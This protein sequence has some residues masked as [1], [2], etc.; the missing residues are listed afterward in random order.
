MS[1]RV[2]TSLWALAWLVFCFAFNRCPADD[3][4]PAD[5]QVD[6]LR[7]S[8]ASRTWMRKL[9][10]LDVR[11]ASAACHHLPMMIWTFNEAKAAA[12]GVNEKSLA[13][14]TSWTIEADNRSKILNPPMVVPD[15][16]VAKGLPIGAP[17]LS[18]ALQAAPQV[19]PPIEAGIQR[20]STL[21]LEK[22]E[23]DGS[24]IPPS[25]R[26]PL[27]GEKNATTWLSLA[28]MNVRSADPTVQ[29]S[30]DASVGSGPATGS[31]RPNPTAATKRR[32]ITCWQWSES[33]RRRKRSKDFAMKSSLVS[34]KTAAGARLRNFPATPMRLVSPSIRSVWG[35]W[36]KKIQE[37]SVP[38]SFF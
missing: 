6:R 36:R 32:R 13:E 37:F 9:D 22:Q 38:C 35:D 2:T 20:L 31:R 28:A 27:L 21:L 1:P 33:A 19:D 4:L 11:A 26:P 29:T 30:I 7:S 17:Y 12:I 15:A 3:S 24:W 5:P 16:P 14:V 18:L 8:G 34:A 23:A 25:G 10:G